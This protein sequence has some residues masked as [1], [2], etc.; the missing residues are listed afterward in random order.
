MSKRVVGQTTALSTIGGTVGLAIVTVATEVLGLS[1]SPEAHWAVLV[2]VTA[3]MSVLGGYLAPS[4]RDEMAQVLRESGLVYSGSDDVVAGDYDE[5][6]T[7][8]YV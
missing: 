7:S 1:L 5:D 4:K 3:G 6:A 8:P 2:L